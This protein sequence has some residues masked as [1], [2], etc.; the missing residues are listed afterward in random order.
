MNPAL[1]DALLVVLALTLLPAAWRGA[2]GPT[3]ADRAIG[4]DH[5]FFVFVAVVALLA[6]RTDR[7][8]I[9]DVVVVA[10]LVGFLSAVTLARYIS[11]SRR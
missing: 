3:E 8:E 9:L 5:A 10:T 1:L 6:L 7:Y 11:R 2:T 4:A